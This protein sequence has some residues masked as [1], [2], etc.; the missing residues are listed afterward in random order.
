LLDVARGIGTTVA[1]SLGRSIGRALARKSRLRG[2]RLL[3]SL[4]ASS[5]ITMR[6]SHVSDATRNVVCYVG[7]VPSFG[8]IH[9]VRISGSLTFCVIRAKF[10]MNRVMAGHDA[11]STSAVMDRHD[12]PIQEDSVA[13]SFSRKVPRQPA[14]FATADTARCWS[15]AVPGPLREK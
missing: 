12:L 3:Q 10:S 6:R 9:R 8:R 1:N 11:V 13:L 7:S 5:R 15:D 14:S 2:G 4:T